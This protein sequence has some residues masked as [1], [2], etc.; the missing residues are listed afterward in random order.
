MF[1]L[2]PANNVRVI[3]YN[4]KFTYLTAE[5]DTASLNDALE[6]LRPDVGHDVALE[7]A[8]GALSSV[9]LAVVP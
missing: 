3:K 1:C 6:W 4:F 2:K 8:L 9:N 7:P 5:S